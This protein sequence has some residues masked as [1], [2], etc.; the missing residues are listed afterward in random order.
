MV[1]KAT[2]NKLCSELSICTCSKNKD[3]LKNSLTFLSKNDYIKVIEDKGI[4]TISLAHAAE[5]R[6]N[7]IKI[8]KA[9]YEI[10]KKA[11]CEASWESLL[12]VFL[13][14]LELAQDQIYTYNKI[15]KMTNLSK[16]TVERCVKTIKKLKFDDT[17]IK[18]TLIKS[19]D[20]KGE[21]KTKGQ[22]YTQV[23][24]WSE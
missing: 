4:Y 6:K 5:K 8:K 20:S 19:K 14:V 23:Y 3:K 13:T 17:V 10:I 22:T 16:S 2:R 15:G 24:D 1:S 18:V 11:D 12:K 7:I 21:Y 9:W